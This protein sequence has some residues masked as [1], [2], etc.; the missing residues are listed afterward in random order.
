MDLQALRALAV[1]A[2]LVNHVWPS[3]MTGGYVGVDVFFVISGFLIT[4]HLLREL[5]RSATVKLTQFYARRI[6]RLL[7]AA[8]LVLVISAV[9]VW[10]WLPYSRWDRNAWEIASSAFYV[11][12]WFLVSQST[13]YSELNA[14]ASVAQHY[15]SLSVEEQFY[16]IWPVFLLGLFWLAT[17]RAKHVDP[18]QATRTLTIGMIGLGVASL[19]LGLWW[20]A[21]HPASAYFATPVRCW[22]FAIGGLLALVARRIPDRRP[23]VVMNLGA[24]AGFGLVIVTCF[25]YDHA[26]PFPGWHALIPA[27]GTGLVILGGSGASDQLWHSH[28]TS[29]KPIQWLGDVSYSLYLWHW[30]LI[31]LAPFALSRPLERWDKVAIALVAVALAGLTKYF[32]EDPGR[33]LAWLSAKTW[34]TYVSML[35]AM[36]LVAACSVVLSQQAKAR[37]NRLPSDIPSGC[38]GPNAMVPGAD[39]PDR[40]GPPEDPVMTDDTNAYW[41]V[42]PGCTKVDEGVRGLECDY[43]GGADNPTHVWLFGDSHGQ[44]WQYALVELATKNQWKLSLGFIGACPGAD[45]T[46]IDYRGDPVTPERQAEC[47]DWHEKV[48][49]G[50]L[51]LRPDM[52]FTS[53]FARAQHVDDGTGR[54]QMDQYV[55]GITEYWQPIIDA[56]I[57][58]YAIGDP[59]LNREVRDP[60]CLL[61]NENDPM[62]CAASR[63]EAQPPDPLLAAAEATNGSV[64][65]IDLTEFFCDENNCYASIGQIP[66]YYDP[67]HLNRQYA[68]L[69]APYLESRL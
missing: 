2:V 26:T 37:S 30:P 54:S 32:V 53:F 69:L 23:T 62:V 50:I 66:I 33:K 42:P 18:E 39:C 57:T 61:L 4:S 47:R 1:G 40:F 14:V 19:G 59:P 46:Y 7:P 16:L 64:T 38:L 9:L 56:G 48:R 45:V 17:R 12:N 55:E 5:M 52:V 20:T 36:A 25:L 67:D 24:I 60:D 15:W 31:V 51:Q 27:V 49:A 29:L 13:N 3:R 34:R 65:G 63:A 10:L 8:L 68:E 28:L 44:Q 6:R 11:E 41:T 58:L 43:S 35:V 22:E 21:Q